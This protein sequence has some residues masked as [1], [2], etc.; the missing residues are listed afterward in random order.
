MTALSGI[1]PGAPLTIYVDGE[2][3]AARDGQTIAA[4]LLAAGTRIVRHTRRN[5]RP[6]GQ[7][8][9]MGVCYDCV[10]TVDGR[11]G[12]RACMV[13]VA[14]GMRVELPRQHGAAP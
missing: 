11:P 2:P 10:V 9:A 13:R 14:E 8:C 12:S 5:G 3:L 1:E 6:R 4:A 7:F